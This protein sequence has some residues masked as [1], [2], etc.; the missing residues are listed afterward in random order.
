MVDRA[1]P[2][3][4]VLSFALVGCL[5]GL[6]TCSCARLFA[7]LPEGLADLVGCVF[8]LLLSAHFWWFDRI[9]SVWRSLGF[10]AASTLAY[11]AATSEGMHVSGL[12]PVKR[13]LF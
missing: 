10:V 13:S 5:A 11:L 1:S 8:G 6:A 9:R 12:W 3:T 4:R 2:R 7:L